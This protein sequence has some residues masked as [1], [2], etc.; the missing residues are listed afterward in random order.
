MNILL[1]KKVCPSEWAFRFPRTMPGSVFGTLPAVIDQGEMLSAIFLLQCLS[2][3]HYY[4]HPLKLQASI[5]IHFSLDSLI[6]LSFHSNRI[7]TETEI[8]TREWSIAVTGLPRLL[9]GGMWKTEN[10]D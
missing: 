3:Y 1:F 10:L 6:M 4:P 8:G 5:Y 2:P 9:F 7:L